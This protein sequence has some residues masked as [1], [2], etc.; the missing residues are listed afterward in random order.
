MKSKDRYTC[1]EEM[2]NSLGTFASYISTCRHET[3]HVNSQIYIYYYTSAFLEAA[4]GIGDQRAT[5]P[6]MQ[7][8]SNYGDDFCRTI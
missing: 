6:Y 3:T 4:V 7:N 5:V 8:P 2:Y 1:I